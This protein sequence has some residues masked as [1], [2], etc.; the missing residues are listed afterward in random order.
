MSFGM[1]R[2]KHMPI[3]GTLATGIAMRPGMLIQKIK[4]EYDA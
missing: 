1:T 2:T 4:I 3:P